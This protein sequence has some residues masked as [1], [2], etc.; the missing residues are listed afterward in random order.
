MEAK[1][2]SLTFLGDEH[3][4]KIPFFQREYV[5]GKNNWEDLLDDLFNFDK[6]HF[7]GSLILKQ[8]KA[9]SG[10]PKEVLVIDGQQRLT[11]LTVLLKA[12][13]DQFDDELKENCKDALT[14]YMFFKKH[15]TDRNY[16][17]KINH[18]KLDSQYFIKVIG[19]ISDKIITKIPDSEYNEINEKSN[20]ILQCYK[21]FYD[22]LLN[23]STEQKKELF[24]KLLD[25][26]NKI[27]VLIDL[28]DEDNE[29]AI[30]DTINSAGV[31]L[32]GTDIVKNALFQKAI[33]LMGTDE[34]VN[35]YNTYWNSV[36]GD[37]D[38][39][40][41]FWNT[42]K[43]TGRLMRDNSEILLHSIAIIEGFYDP[44]K[45][46]L[47]KLADLYKQKIIGLD[48]NKI[49]NF[50][51]E[52]SEYAKIYFEK[53]S[54]YENT[55]QYSYDNVLVRLLHIL[56]NLELSTFHPL[57]L[58]WV[59]K[60]RDTSELNTRLKVLES[61]VIKQMLSHGE[62]KS[63]N[64][65]CKDFIAN[66]VEL[67]NKTAAITDAE[68]LAGLEQIANKN[69]T[70]ILFWIELYRRFNDVKQSVKNL[71]YAYTLEHIMPQKWEEY[72]SVVPYYDEN[73][74]AVTAPESGK[75]KRYKK[76]YALGN[77]T[78]LNHRLNT[79]LRNYPFA[80]KIEGDTTGRKRK[81]M[82]D[83]SDLSVTKDILTDFDNGDKNWD[84]RNIN[85]RTKLLGNEILNIWKIV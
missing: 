1:A 71:A 9:K 58:F 57:I 69:A 39:F 85:T 20:K 35:L 27:I 37:D 38:D 36:F 5:W 33:E 60:Y 17:I 32:S 42:Q 13:Y 34:T 24:N 77:M 3:S 82:K 62:T 31:R 61:Y 21:Y 30:F 10:E 72:W 23:K 12:I 81:G 78:L 68:V 56:D 74:N 40:V 4:V 51:Q 14:K 65:V 47:E 80:K 7:L 41:A 63:Y 43:S 53:F 84:E 28:T 2:R 6:T 48:N 18:S 75:E 66:E 64:K 67:F 26:E 11:T 44:E 79:S 83:Y 54:E 55:K 49:T 73:G 29:Q 25:S 52:I 50:I 8:Q 59:K 45:H 46:T 16:E 70:I 15:S 19:N 22:A 76:I